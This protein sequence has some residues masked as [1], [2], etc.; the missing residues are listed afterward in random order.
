MESWPGETQLGTF[1]CNKI[2]EAGG[3]RCKTAGPCTVHCRRRAQGAVFSMAH[4]AKA[5]QGGGSEEGKLRVQPKGS[6]RLHHGRP[7]GDRRRPS[8]STRPR[9]VESERKW[10]WLCPYRRSRV[11][12]AHRNPA[13]FF[14]PVGAFDS[15]LI[16]V[17]ALVFWLSQGTADNEIM[18]GFLD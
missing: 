11:R 4:A 5:K 14:R 16:L 9:L 10:V 3:C 15:N 2:L 17:S 1:G 7:A 13:I 18:L 6:R 8:G 12:C